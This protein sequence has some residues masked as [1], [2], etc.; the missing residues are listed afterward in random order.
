[1][2][3]SA[4]TATSYVFESGGENNSAAASALA[5]SE[6]SNSDSRSYWAAA[7]DF[8]REH[9]QSLPSLTIEG[10]VENSERVMNRID[11]DKDKLIS[12]QEMSIA[13][14]NPYI[15]GNDAQVLAAIYRLGDTAASLHEGTFNP[16]QQIKTDRIKEDLRTLLDLGSNANS[17]E[18]GLFEVQMGVVDLNS[19]RIID[20]GEL[21]KARK[22]KPREEA[23]EQQKKK[24]K[25]K[26]KKKPSPEP[27]AT[28]VPSQRMCVCVFCLALV[29][30]LL[31]PPPL[32]RSLRRD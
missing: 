26:S 28:P 19:D 7:N 21:V 17:K 14:D 12:A 5:G 25:K 10:L 9:Q 11:L 6:L 16:M 30:V 18:D 23:E 20:R 22:N 24:S 29:V 3:Q 8:K 1:M 27:P 32:P 4:E 31:L 2:N 13:V 15:I